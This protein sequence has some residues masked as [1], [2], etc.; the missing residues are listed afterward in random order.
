MQINN[1]YILMVITLANLLN[2][3]NIIAGNS[4]ND[5]FTLAQVDVDIPY[6]FEEAFKRQTLDVKVMLFEEEVGLGTIDVENE[7]LTFFELTLSDAVAPKYK[8]LLEKKLKAEGL[9]FEGLM[10]S[11]YDKAT[12]KCPPDELLISFDHSIQDSTVHM[13]FSSEVLN[14]QIASQDETSIQ[15]IDESDSGLSALFQYGYNHSLSTTNDNVYN[16]DSE[17]IIS[18]GNHNL[19]ISTEQYSNLQGDIVTGIGDLYWMNKSEGMYYSV[20]RYSKFNNFNYNIGSIYDTN[21][22]FIGVSFGSAIDTI[23]NQGVDSD[24]PIEIVSARSGRAEVFR[25]EQLIDTVN[26]SPGVQE[27]DTTHWP[28][29]VYRVAIKIYIGDTLSEEQSHMVYKNS[30][31]A[32]SLPAWN[33]QAGVIEEDNTKVSG[34]LRL[35]ILPGYGLILGSELQSDNSHLEIGLDGQLA[36]GA[37]FSMNSMYS[38]DNDYGLNIRYDDYFSNK[39]SYAIYYDYF[40]SQEGFKT[41]KELNNNVTNLSNNYSASDISVHADWS[42]DNDNSI[43]LSLYYNLQEER[44]RNTIQ[45]ISYFNAGN[46][47]NINMTSSVSKSKYDG[48]KDEYVVSL[49]FEVPIFSQNGTNFRIGSS[50]GS[51]SGGAMANVSYGQNIEDST[52]QYID[53]NAS[54]GTE[55]TVDA[56]TTVSLDNEHVAGYVSAGVY[57]HETTNVTS[58]ANIRGQIAIGESGHIGASSQSSQAAL[59]VSTNEDAIGKVKAVVDGLNFPLNSDTTLIPVDAFEQLQVNFEQLEDSGNDN[60]YIE[61]PSQHY[62]LSAGNVEHLDVTATKTV[63]VLGQLFDENRQSV[64]SARVVNHVSSAHTEENGIFSAQISL[65]EPEIIFYRA[66]GVECKLNLEEYVS[67]LDIPVLLLERVICHSD[68]YVQVFEE[69]I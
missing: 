6:G 14:N 60:F 33:I 19:N 23:A 40:R 46:M 27:L 4:E 17:L 48:F 65:L 68:G 57:Q 18:S 10:C 55:G 34:R 59:L 58:S 13:T 32:S 64:A 28:F 21:E 41:H 50:Y 45:Y 66:D 1:I 52:I 31:L 39:L 11:V 53:V 22:E 25:G 56:Y 62:T 63:E 12:I 15:Y 44:M 47:N 37:Y 54:A 43:R 35:P 38:F 67:G 30:T 42:I 49:N 69:K 8:S 51:Q 5:Y 61:T 24:V 29:G 7:K 3:D 20:G 26:L 16:L 36:S 2:I 9:P